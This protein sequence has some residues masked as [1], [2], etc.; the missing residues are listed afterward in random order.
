MANNALSP[1]GNREILR[2]SSNRDKPGGNENK[3][4]TEN[5]R[6]GTRSVQQNATSPAAFTVR[7]SE[8]FEFY[9]HSL[10]R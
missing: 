2:K 4:R 8:E 5:Q 10:R 6:D 1:G 7:H 3:K 9:P